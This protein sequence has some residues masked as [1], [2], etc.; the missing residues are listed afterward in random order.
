MKN[1]SIYFLI[2]ISFNSFSFSQNIEQGKDYTYQIDDFVV[3]ASR[4]NQSLNDLSPSV[5]VFSK[6]AIKEGL[7]LNIRD[8]LNQVPGI[9]I[10]ANGGMGKTTSMFTRGSESNHTA[11]LLN[12]RRMPTGNSGLYDLG[13]LG[14]SNTRSIEVVRGDNSSL[15]GGAIGGVVNIRSGQ[16]SKGLN[17]NFNFETGSD[18]GKFYNYNYGFSDEILS[19]NFSVN[20][21]HTDGYV[22]NSAFER[23]SANLYFLYDLNN[24][25]DLDFQYL[26]Y[27]TSVEVGTSF[28][29]PTMEENLTKAYM[30][31]PGLSFDI[32][33]SSKLKLMANFS[34]NELD[35]IKTTGSYDR[36]FSEKI[37]SLESVYEITHTKNKG[38][39][40]FGLLFEKRRYEEN[41]INDYNLSNIIPYEVSY[42]TKSFFTNTIYDIDPI[43]EIELGGR[44]DSFSNNF[45]TSRSGSLKYTK[46]LKNLSNSSIHA[47]YSYGK[48][49][50][51]LL[52]LAYGNNYNFFL[53]DSNIQLE[54]IK[55]REVG[56]K[57]KF[58]NQELG[59]IY[60]DNSIFN[61]SATDYTAYPIVQRILIDTKQRG[62]ETYLSGNLPFEI[63]Y[64]ISYS[65]LNAKDKEG[66][67]LIR[68]PKHKW[69]ASVS[70]V[71]EDF[72]IGLNIINI[73]GLIDSGDVQLDDYTVA[74]IFGTYLLNNKTSINFRFENAL[75]E[76]YMYL[77]GY[78]GAPRQGYIGVTYDF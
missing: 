3:T 29:F 61:L 2:F 53:T 28:G 27:D 34:K 40:I 75:D 41:P 13:N 65:Y 63:E 66:N 21:D 52:V 69:I 68:R 72:N 50:P 58:I 78:S 24:S 39:S 30:Y 44:I 25:V 56:F 16:S 20:S 14:L 4:L 37:N 45:D 57:T 73:S 60:F 17:Q 54:T 38:R 31:S 9:H 47:K 12:G 71:F 5:Y 22:E 48:N 59:F 18:G 35:A 42:D 67:Q 32:S 46:K 36:R 33:G 26:F 70:R 49:P 55:S 43:T 15:Y 74:R 76:K 51:D 6:E 1:L 10:A 7:Y 62:S 23:D 64:L 11:I 77:N 19:L 8:V